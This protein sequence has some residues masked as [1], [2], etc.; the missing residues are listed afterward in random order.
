M[1]LGYWNNCD[2]RAGGVHV[3]SGRI[4][5]YWRTLSAHAD[6][7]GGTRSVPNTHLKLLRA[8]RTSTAGATWVTNVSPAIL[9]VTNRLN[10]YAYRSKFL[11]GTSGNDYCWNILK[12][13][14][15]C[16]RPMI[17]TVGDDRRGHSLCAWG[18][19]RPEVR[20]HVQHL[21]PRQG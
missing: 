18:I 14:I 21:G 20:D 13:E 10:D 8:M 15:R 3:G 16:S 9:S 17:W 2:A 12:E 7:T 6:G 4:T 19:H 11:E 1:V 5:D